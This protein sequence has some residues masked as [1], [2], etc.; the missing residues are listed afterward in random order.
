MVCVMLGTVKH[1]IGGN[2]WWYHVKLRVIDE[3]NS[4]IFI[5]FDRDCYLL[6]KMTCLDLI[7]E[8]DG[9]AEP[10]IM[11]KV[12]GGFVDQTFLFKIDV[13]SDD[14]IEVEVDLNAGIVQIDMAAGVIQDLNSVVKTSV[15]VDDNLSNN[16]VQS[17]LAN[18]VGWDLSIKFDN[19][20]AEDKSEGNC[21]VPTDIEPDSADCTSIKRGIIQVAGDDDEA[22]A[23]IMKTIKIEKE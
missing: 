4:S 20:G 17:K 3:T 9:E 14:S 11:P 18:G 5:L 19:V 10:G 15:G 12:I 7:A 23:R 22:N 16:P 1:V 6:T 8:I 21:A 13:K 2:D